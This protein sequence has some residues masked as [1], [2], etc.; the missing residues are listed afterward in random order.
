MCLR[1][2]ILFG[3][4]LASSDFVHCFGTYG[5]EGETGQGRTREVVI[6]ARVGRD[7]AKVARDRVRMEMGRW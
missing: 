2:L 3:C 7:K 5:T 1:L 6:E 4:L